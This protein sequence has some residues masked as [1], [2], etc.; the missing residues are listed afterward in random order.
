M[1]LDGTTLVS[2]C[3]DGNLTLWGWFSMIS[4]F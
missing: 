1:S 4:F 3:K 2:G